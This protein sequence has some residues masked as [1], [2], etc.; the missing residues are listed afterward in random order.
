MNEALYEGSNSSGLFPTIW[1]S[2]PWMDPRDVL[3][4]VTVRSKTGGTGQEVAMVC[5]E[6]PL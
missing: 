6:T 1:I 3:A 5:F 2:T 4:V